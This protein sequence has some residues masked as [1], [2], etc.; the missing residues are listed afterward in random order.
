MQPLAPSL[1]RH[2]TSIT[3]EEEKGAT[4]PRH[5]TSGAPGA[6]LHRRHPRRQRSSVNGGHKHP[7][8]QISQR[9]SHIKPWMPR[10]WPTSTAHDLPLAETS[11]ARGGGGD[12]L[13][14]HTSF[15]RPAPTVAW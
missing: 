2:Q 14:G 9:G 7:H 13:A 4:P 5:S 11:E 3:I 10:I 6:T 15:R 1:E 12:G 8:R